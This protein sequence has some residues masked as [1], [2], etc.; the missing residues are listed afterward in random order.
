M[1]S[2]SIFD[3]RFSIVRHAHFC[4]GGPLMRTALLRANRKSKIENRKSSSP[5]HLV[6]L[7]PCHRFPGA[8]VAPPPPR[9]RPGGPHV[10]GQFTAQPLRQRSGHRQGHHR[11][12]NL[13]L[14]PH[15]AQR[16]PRPA[17]LEPSLPVNAYKTYTSNSLKA[18]PGQPTGKSKLCLSCHD[19]TIALGSVNSR[20]QPI[21]MAGGITTIPAGSK[22]NLGTDLSD[23]HPISFSYDSDLVDQEPQAQNPRAFSPPPCNSTPNKELQCTTCHDAHNNQYGNFLVCHQH[24]LRPLQHLPHHGHSPTITQ[25]T[26]C[27]NCHKTHTAPSGPYL[28][29]QAKVADTCLTCHNGSA[30]GAN[31]APISPSPLAAPY[32]HDTKPAGQSR[33]PHPQQLRL[34]R[35]PRT[36]HHEAAPRPPNAGPRHPGH[37]RQNR[38]RHHRRRRD[39]RTA[40][41]EYEVCFKC[42]ADNA[43][44]IT[45]RVSRAI[46]QANMRLRFAPTAV[47]LPPRRRQGQ[48]PQRPLAPP[49]VTPT[50]FH[51][52][53]H[54]LPRLRHASKKAGGSGAQRPPRLH[55]PRP[56]PG[57]LRHRRPH[58]L[59]HHRLRPLLQMPRQHRWSSP[60]R[61]PFPKHKSARPDDQA[62]CSACHDSHGIPS[63][64]GTALHNSAPHQLRHLDR[65]PR[66]HHAQ[67]PIHPHRPSRTAPAPSSATATTTRRRRIE[68]ASSVICGPWSVGRP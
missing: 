35:L 37:A 10:C 34:Q 13:H 38:R 17:A 67:D 41:Y 28:L 47:S 39:R 55:L 8:G 30:S 63:T 27:N 22:T 21:Q 14:L 61:G 52:L 12:R 31:R 57:P 53:L 7:S 60:T 64:Q 51:D 68:G 23:D 56:P 19:G 29:K 65:V 18:L 59:L 9:P 16:H 24:Q 3:F 26:T 4:R 5:C 1:K 36:A 44:N 11:I 66:R 62:P 42:H 50:H 58:A 2:F 6:T 32:T 20:N 48:E 33:R 43:A 15:P 25:H 45:T 40:Q 49:S 46:T 54:R